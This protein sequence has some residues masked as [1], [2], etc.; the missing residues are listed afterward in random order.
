M[1]FRFASPWILVAL[2]A[3]VAVA[4]WVARR[5]RLS[6]ARVDLP[7]ASGALPLGRSG[8]VILERCMPW[9]RGAVLVLAVLAL[10]RPQTGARVE[11]ISSVGID[12]VVALD[13]SQSM[14]AEDFQPLNR[15]EVAKRTMASFV[16]GRK[17]DRIGLVTF[18]S[19]A[20]TRCPLTLDHAMLLDLLDRV[21]FAPPDET[22]TAI[23]MGLA[24]ATNRLRGSESKGQVV[25]LL[26]DGRNNQGEIGPAAAAEAARALG[27]RVY[28]IGVGTEGE[29]PIRIDTPRGPEYRLQRLDLDEDLL[30]EIATATGGRY[31]RATDPRA[32]EETFRT[33]D[34]LEKTE[35]RSRVRVLYG[36]RFG[37]F[38][39]PAAMLLA[40]EWLLTATRL[41]RIP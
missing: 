21:D 35:I 14:R 39:L 30:R 10:A 29:A 2:V 20:T 25:V 34:D 16:D 15:L 6:D 23:G 1:I 28:T 41:R 11:S 7:A 26:T 33:I 12:I 4:W 18:A 5:R 24:S 38:L 22:G 31:F 37:Y 9:V 27:V 3:A 8:W 13:V 40:F 36:E 17:A 32:L 19:L